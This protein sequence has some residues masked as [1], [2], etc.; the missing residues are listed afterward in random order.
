M[1]TSNT[2]K[3]PQPE[4]VEAAI[5]KQWLDQQAVTLVDVR[6]P[7]EY[8]TEHIA[9]SI[10]VPL[11][12]FNP[13]QV[14]NTGKKVVVYCQKGSRSAR[15]AQ[16]L[17]TSGWEVENLASLQGGLEAWKAGGYETKINKKAPLSLMRQV[18]IVAGSLVL[19]GTL[20]GA[21]VSPWFLVV[22][23]FVGAGLTF[24]GITNTCALAFLLSKLPLNQQVKS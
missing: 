12:K 14:P 8:A 24:A 17:F 9:G 3:I 10:L 22:S 6:E 7:V 15:A 20:L 5:L 23:G 21:F 1:I 11:S 18:Q 16:Q 4:A 2:T 13:S 19:T